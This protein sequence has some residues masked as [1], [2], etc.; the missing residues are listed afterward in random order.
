VGVA[1]ALVQREQHRLQRH[2]VSQHA[3]F[4]DRGQQ[5]LLARQQ[6]LGAGQVIVRQRREH[7]AATDQ[8]QLV[9]LLARQPGVVFEARRRLVHAAEL[10]QR[11]GLQH[12]RSPALD[13]VGAGIL[14]QGSLRLGGQLECAA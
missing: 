13:H 10:H 11:V 8:P 9:A 6:R 2:R 7:R 4:A 5:R 1:L 12:A 14:A 3:T